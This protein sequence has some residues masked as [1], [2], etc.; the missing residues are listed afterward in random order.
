MQSVMILGK[1]NGVV[2]HW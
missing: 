1:N 2:E